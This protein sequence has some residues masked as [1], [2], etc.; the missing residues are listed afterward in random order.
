MNI[1]IV[2]PVYNEGENIQKN[3]LK[4]QKYLTGLDDSYRIMMVYDFEEDN[5]LPVIRAMQYDYPVPIAMVKNDKR[6]AVHAIKKGFRTST[7]DYVMVSMADLSDDY[8]IVGRMADLARQGYDVICA[9]RY[10]KGGMLHGGPFIKQLLSRIAGVSLYYL[11]GI[12]THDITN[13]FKLYRREMLNAMDLESEGGFEIAL[14]ITAKA[15]INGYRIG[16]VPAHWW[17]RTGGESKFQIMRWLPRYLNWYFFLLFSR[18]K[19][20]EG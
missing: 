14:E 1:D 5:T 20:H 16:E 6:G 2:I 11:K 13:S 3:L 12:P 8:R 9:S 7:A 19:R 10:M 4:L 17:D 15:Y 18:R